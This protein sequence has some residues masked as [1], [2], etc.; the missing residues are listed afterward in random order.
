VN[1]IQRF[2]LEVWRQFFQQQGGTFK[3]TAIAVLI[4]ASSGGVKANWAEFAK[5]A[6]NGG[7]LRSGVA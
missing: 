7:I 6:R 5:A 1:G 3:H 4:G 2:I